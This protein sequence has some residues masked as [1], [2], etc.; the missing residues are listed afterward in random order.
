[1]D[2]SRSNKLAWEHEISFP[3]NM[4][5]AAFKSVLGILYNRSDLIN[6]ANTLRAL[7]RDLSL[8]ENGFYRDC[9]D[10]G[11]DKLIVCDE[12]TEA[13]QYYAFFFKIATPET[14][15]KLWKTLLHDFGHDRKETGKFPD[16]AFANAF[17]GN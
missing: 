2:A 17:I 6:E 1:M 7:I 13:T 12:C 10:H 5:Y 11:A 14:D 16:I 15:P 4:V 9:A 8:S 3:T